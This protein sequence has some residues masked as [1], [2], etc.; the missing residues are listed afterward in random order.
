MVTPIMDIANPRERLQVVLQ[1]ISEEA[2]RRR[3]VHFY[4]TLMKE[5]NIEEVVNV[6]Q[7]KG[8]ITVTMDAEDSDL[9]A[10]FRDAGFNEAHY[11][12]VRRRF[13]YTRSSPSMGGCDCPKTTAEWETHR[14]YLLEALKGQ[15]SA[16]NVKF[17]KKDRITATCN[18][19]APERVTQDQ[20]A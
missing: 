3:W 16:T 8:V 19:C 15:M 6:R 18:F 9:E 12:T 10:K 4:D 14:A 11:I 5:V 1:R 20:P 13:E 2:H 7:Y 17:D